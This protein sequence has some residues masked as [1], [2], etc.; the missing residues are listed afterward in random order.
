MLLDVL[1][2]D[3]KKAA[4]LAPMVIALRKD[5]GEEVR[6]PTE[7]MEVA[8]DIV[9]EIERRRA[10]GLSDSLSRRTVPA[11]TAHGS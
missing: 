10:S 6:A 7:V 8:Q 1:L 9:E 2:L 4:A 3:E 5:M 11:S